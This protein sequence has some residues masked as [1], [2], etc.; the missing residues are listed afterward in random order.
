MFHRFK[1]EIICAR[2]E[3]SRSCVWLKCHPPL[4][5]RVCLQ[6]QSSE[7]LH[8]PGNPE[9]TGMRTAPRACGLI[10]APHQNYSQWM[11]FEMNKGW[12]Y[13]LILYWDG[14][15]RAWFP[16]RGGLLSNNRTLVTTLIAKTVLSLGNCSKLTSK[17]ESLS[18]DPL[19]F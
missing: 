16:P 14:G 13:F 4:W 8:M 18:S 2:R 1:T 17:A 19:R 9:I 7:R 15:G 10:Y 5:F 12:K 3:C 6:T 11:W